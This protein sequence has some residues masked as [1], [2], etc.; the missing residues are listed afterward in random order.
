MRAR[1][2]FRRCQS[3]ILHVTPFT[4]VSRKQPR[5]RVIRT[6]TGHAQKLISTTRF[7]LEQGNA[8]PNR[9]LSVTL[10]RERISGAMYCTSC[11]RWQSTLPEAPRGPTLIWFTSTHQF[12]VQ[13]EALPPL[14][15][16]VDMAASG[17]AFGKL[18]AG[19][20]F[21]LVLAVVLNSTIPRET[22]P[23]RPESIP[24][25]RSTVLPEAARV[26]QIL[27]ARFDA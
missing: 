2:R 15:P 18:M 14:L 27:G 5:P 11:D 20:I 22:D 12:A 4:P 3:G 23:R 9:V 6:A 10:R 26:V 16:A 17:S 25:G 8:A 1:F 24:D 21:H 19:R 13:Y 7:V